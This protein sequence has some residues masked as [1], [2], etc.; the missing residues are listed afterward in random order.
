[1][2]E[3]RV[4]ALQRTGSRFPS[5]GKPCVQQLVRGWLVVPDRDRVDR[6][7]SR[8]VEDQE[9]AIGRSKEHVVGVLV[10]D[11]HIRGPKRRLLN[12]RPPE[13]LFERS[14]RGRSIAQFECLGH[15]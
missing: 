12:D 8:G 9:R 7:E 1:M 10:L 11:D 5:G 4:T 2:S 13:R 3:D 14:V 15:G 6:A